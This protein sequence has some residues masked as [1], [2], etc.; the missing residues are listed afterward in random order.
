MPLQVYL[1]YS[2]VPEGNTATSFHVFRNPNN[3]FGKRARDIY[4]SLRRTGSSFGKSSEREEGRGWAPTAA[5][6]AGRGGGEG[7]LGWPTP[8]RGTG[9]LTGRRSS[10]GAKKSP[11]HR[12]EAGRA[13]SRSRGRKRDAAADGSSRSHGRRSRS[14][15]SSRSRSRGGRRSGSRD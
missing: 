8:T 9:R 3:E 7:A 13:G 6:T 4:L 10:H 2:S 12:S 1:K 5:T 11:K 14:Q 15:S